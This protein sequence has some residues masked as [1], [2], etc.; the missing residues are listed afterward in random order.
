MECDTIAREAK[1]SAEN[2]LELQRD[3]A[4]TADVMCFGIYIFTFYL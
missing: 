4:A 2:C 3:L 1:T